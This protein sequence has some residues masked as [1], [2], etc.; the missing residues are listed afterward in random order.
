MLQVFPEPLLG[1]FGGCPRGLRVAVAQLL[2]PVL[3]LKL[4]PDQPG[5]GRVTQGMQAG[6]GDIDGV[7]QRP[8][9]ESGRLW[10]AA[11]DRRLSPTRPKRW[12]CAQRVTG[13]QHF[14]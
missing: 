10:R 2:G 9:L 6:I 5:P 7:A 1:P 11:D 14:F 4:G 8:E 12:Q 13:Q 3:Q